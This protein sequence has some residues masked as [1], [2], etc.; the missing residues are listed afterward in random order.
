M[1]LPSLTLQLRSLPSAVVTRVVG[2]MGRSDS[3]HG[4]AHPSRAA[5]WCLGTTL[6]GL[7]CCVVFSADVPSPLPRRTRRTGLFWALDGPCECDSGGLPS[8]SARSASARF[9]SRPARR[10]PLLRPVCLLSRPGRPFDIESFSRFVASST[11][12]TATGWDN[13]LPGRDFHPLENDTFA[14]RTD[15]YIYRIHSRGDEFFRGRPR[16]RKVA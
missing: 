7:P 15:K 5:G 4:P 9:V 14:R 3:R 8:L 6:T 12:P 16:R 13:Q 11:V 2:T 10:S 1:L